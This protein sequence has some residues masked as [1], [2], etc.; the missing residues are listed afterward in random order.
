MFLRSPVAG[1]RVYLQPR[2]ARGV[3]SEHLLVD[4]V[5]VVQAHFARVVP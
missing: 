3:R 4:G 1:L 5:N 2:G